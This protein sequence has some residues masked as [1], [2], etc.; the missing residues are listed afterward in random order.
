MRKLDKFEHVD[1]I[2]EFLGFWCVKVLCLS[3]FKGPY[4]LEMQA[5]MLMD[6]ICDSNMLWTGEGV[7]AS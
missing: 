1:Y 3:L 5:K 6:K 2:E 4:V 7:D